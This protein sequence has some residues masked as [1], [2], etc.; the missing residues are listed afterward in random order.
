MFFK[1]QSDILIQNIIQSPN[2]EKVIWI[3][4]FFLVDANNIPKTVEQCRSKLREE[5][6]KHKDLTDIRIV[7]ML[8]I[9]G[10]MELQETIEKWKQPTHIMRYWKDTIEPKP[11]DFL[12]KFISGKN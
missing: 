8:V 2:N 7:D 9:K 4:F 5:F 10:K 6:L 11:A 12:S 3:R 1:P